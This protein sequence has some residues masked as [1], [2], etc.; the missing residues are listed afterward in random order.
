MFTGGDSLH[1]SGTH[2]CRTKKNGMTVL[3]VDDSPQFRELIR[4]VLAGLVD[5]VNECADGDEA[6]AAYRAQR[7]DWVL[8]DLR[9]A[10]MG[11][12]E[13][14]R[15]LRAADPTARVVIVTDYDDA[16]WR[17]ASF[18]AGA[19]GYVLKENLLDVRRMLEPRERC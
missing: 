2:L 18:E 5:Q 12:L 8:M 17:A 7:P 14:T 13:T 15:R 4:T 9:M 19:C 11:G 6:V 3:I 10:R 16:H 1:H